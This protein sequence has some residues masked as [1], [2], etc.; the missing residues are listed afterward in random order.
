MFD[1]EQ[2]GLRGPVKSCREESAHPAM[3]GADGKN[4][5]AFGIFEGV[6][7]GWPHTSY[8]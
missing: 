6:R 2:H 1:R 7:P 8:L 3:I 4:G 5:S